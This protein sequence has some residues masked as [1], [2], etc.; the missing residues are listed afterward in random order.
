[1]TFLTRDFSLFYK[2]K[3]LQEEGVVEIERDPERHLFEGEGRFTYKG[4][5]IEFLSNYR[6][7]A[8]WNPRFEFRRSF[9]IAWCPHHKVELAI[10]ESIDGPF[11]TIPKLQI[12]TPHIKT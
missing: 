9:D 4:K 3:R 7:P 12:K 10:S 5:P 11:Q 2:L 6:G 1:M 8:P